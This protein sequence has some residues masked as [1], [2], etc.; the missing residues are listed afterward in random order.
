MDSRSSQWHDQLTVS[1]GRLEI[2]FLGKRAPTDRHDAFHEHSPSPRHLAFLSQIHSARVIEA[3]PGHC[4][5]ADAFWTRRDDLALSVVTADCVPLVVADQHRLAVAHAG[6]RGIAGGI[7][8]RTVKALGTPDDL[9]AWIGPAIGPCCYEVGDD[10]ARRVVAASSHSI[11]TS[12]TRGRP[13]LDLAGAIE[14]QLLGSGVERVHQSG[15]CTR[16]QAREFWSYRFSG[17]K[18]GRNFTFAWLDGR[19]AGSVSGR[20]PDPGE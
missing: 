1:H 9:S 13:H 7:V 12:G 4:G 11:A 10:V 16:C 19:H 15:V 14:I 17:P 18:A 3:T 20:S 6:W 2:R 8:G 5:K